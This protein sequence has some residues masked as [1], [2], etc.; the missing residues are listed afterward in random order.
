[1]FKLTLTHWLWLCRLCFAM[2]APFLLQ[3]RLCYFFPQNL[4]IIG[5]CCHQN[6]GLK[7]CKIHW[8]RLL[9]LCL[10]GDS[11]NLCSTNQGFM[12]PRA[13]AWLG[14][15]A[16]PRWL[17]YLLSAF[18]KPNI[19]SWTVRGYSTLS[20]IFNSEFSKPAFWNRAQNYL[21]SQLIFGFFLF[22]SWLVLILNCVFSLYLG[23]KKKGWQLQSTAS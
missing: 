3:L 19:P 14:V 18:L 1:M 13:R 22:T 9:S 7:R 2:H 5:V 20:I 8:P 17:D 6:F 4:H 15:K 11:L 16:T 23:P 10:H 12:Y 21:D